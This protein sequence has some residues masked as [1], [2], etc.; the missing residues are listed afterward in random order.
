[1]RGAA[2]PGA[3]PPGA[4]CA[5]PA[6]THSSS[7]TPSK[8]SWGSGSSLLPSRATMAL[9]SCGERPSRA[10]GRGASP[11]ALPQGG[12]PRTH[13]LLLLLIRLL[14]QVHGRRDELPSR[15][16]FRGLAHCESGVTMGRE[17][18]VPLI[19]APRSHP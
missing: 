9:R 2:G 5:P 14:L 3:T 13:L 10:V 15:S 11:P 17:G 7:S 4:V 18:F 16:L 1:M 8:E 12:H 19:K 6:L